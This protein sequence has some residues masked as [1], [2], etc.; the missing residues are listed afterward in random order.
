MLD[1]RNR[2]KYFL[3]YGTNHVRGLEKMKDAMWKIAPVGGEYSFSDR[4]YPQITLFEDLFNEDHLKDL[5]I[6]NYRQRRVMISDIEDYVVSR[7]PYKKAHTKKA[8]RKLE[9]ENS[10]T[11]TGRSR[12]MTF[13]DGCIINFL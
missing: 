2:T 8:L 1:S 4:D 5:L 6:N 11:I 9:E 7:T 3:Y 10:I 13:P 12:R